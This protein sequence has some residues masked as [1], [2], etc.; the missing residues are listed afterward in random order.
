M[1]YTPRTYTPEPYG[2]TLYRGM[3][4]LAIWLDEDPEKVV[5]TNDADFKN[6]EIVNQT[7]KLVAGL[8]DP[9]EDLLHKTD[10]AIYLTALL[11]WCSAT[12]A[13]AY[14]MQQQLLKELAAIPT[15]EGEAEIADIRHSLAEVQEILLESP[16]FAAAKTH[17][18]L[19]GDAEFVTRIDFLNPKWNTVSTDAEKK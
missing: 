7:A 10:E 4:Q 14:R 8:R 15:A 9:D 11:F 3:T 5:R 13:M 17:A 6:V 1:A 16:I 19:A 12:F 18:A 2:S